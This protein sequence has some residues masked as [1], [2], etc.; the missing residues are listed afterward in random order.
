MWKY[1][2]S[3]QAYSWLLFNGNVTRLLNGH[4]PWQHG[5]PQLCPLHR[6]EVAG[7]DHFS[8]HMKCRFMVPFLLQHHLNVSDPPWSLSPSEE[9]VGLQH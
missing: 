3:T 5:K 2:Q 9:A 1:P 4:P 7:S 8:N 6:P